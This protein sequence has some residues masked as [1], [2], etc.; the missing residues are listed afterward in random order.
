MKKNLF[1]NYAIVS[2]LSISSSLFSVEPENGITIEQYFGDAN[3]AESATDYAE[4]ATERLTGGESPIRGEMIV[5]KMEMFLHPILAIY[6][7]P[8]PIVTIITCFIRP[9]SQFGLDRNIYAN[10][11]KEYV[12]RFPTHPVVS[13][14]NNLENDLEQAT[15]ESGK[16]VAVHLCRNS[17][18]IC[19]YCCC[20][21]CNC[22]SSRCT[23]L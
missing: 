2:L 7:G 20:C 3:Y 4:S 13:D 6:A 15:I 19:Y 8:A 23:L 11:V 18:P 1:L 5:I 12:F 17:Y 22:C 21:C 16:H 10:Y 14:V 9:N